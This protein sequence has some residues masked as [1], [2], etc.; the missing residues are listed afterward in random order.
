[1]VTFG[2]S[3]VG[4]TSI[5]ISFSSEY[6]VMLALLILLGL[7]AGA[8]HPSA[9]A[10]L[11]GMFG[12]KSRGKVLAVHM[13]GGSTGFMLGPVLGALAAVTLGWRFAFLALSVPTLL[14]AILIGVMFWR[15]SGAAQDESGAA[16]SSGGV[17]SNDM[18]P[19]ISLWQAIRPL[20]RVIGIVV[21]VQLIAGS[22]SAFLPVY[23]VDVHGITP[24]TATM[25]LGVMRGG[26]I[27]G[28]LI[29]GW[30]SDRWNRKYVILLA[31][32]ITGL[33]L[34]GLTNLPYGPA[35]V[36]LMGLFGAAMYMRGAAVQ[37]YLMDSVPPRMRATVF[38]IYFGLGM[39]GMSLAQPVAGHFMDLYG[40]DG[41]FRGI[42]VIAALLALVAPLLILRWRKNTIL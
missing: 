41:V 36:V 38:G 8:Y 1:V 13:V 7:F 23:L 19:R 20:L 27:V 25:M 18:A 31:M 40:I 11:S 16:A 28:S 15:Q 10:F 21:L 14:A 17:P 26:G 34:L 35:S 39:E 30:L 2:L 5:A 42:A 33:V 6:Y 9:V 37:V 22:A 3:G 24:A 32:V 29:S 4:L 12:Q